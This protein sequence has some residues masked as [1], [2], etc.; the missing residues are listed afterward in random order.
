LKTKDEYFFGS[1]EVKGKEKKVWTLDSDGDDDWCFP[2]VVVSAMTA[3]PWW[4]VGGL[5]GCSYPPG[6]SLL[7]GWVRCCGLS[8]VQVGSIVSHPRW[9]KNVATATAMSWVHVRGCV[10]VGYSKVELTLQ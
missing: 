1:S 2:D 5:R 7:L 3:V 9:D 8:V 6:G 4:L 10:C